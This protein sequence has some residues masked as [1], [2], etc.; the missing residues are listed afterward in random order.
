MALSVLAGLSI[1]VLGE[2]HL[3]ISGS[4]IESLMTS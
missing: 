3:T 1:L 4:L 2:S